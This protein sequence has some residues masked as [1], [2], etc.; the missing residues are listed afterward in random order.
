MTNTPLQALSYP[1]AAAGGVAASAG[2]TRALQM[3]LVSSAVGPPAAAIV[4]AP[5]ASELQASA[6]A[7]AA[8]MDTSEL[9]DL[10][11]LISP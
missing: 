1:G 8:A 3:H 4:V 11:P 5:T 9:D 6:P 7:S 10:P 2:T